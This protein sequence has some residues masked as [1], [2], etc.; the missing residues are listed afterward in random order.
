[1][2]LLN[3]YMQ[4]GGCYRPLC[5]APKPDILCRITEGAT[6]AAYTPK[7]WDDDGDCLQAPKGDLHG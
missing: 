6:S 4:C 3:D 1:M 5:D 2:T 7:D